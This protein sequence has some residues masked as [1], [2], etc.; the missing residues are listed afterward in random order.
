[1]VSGAGDGIGRQ[2]ALQLI[3]RGARVAAVGRTES[4]L[5]GTAAQSLAPERMSAHALD[6]SD[7]AAVFE[8]V[9]KVLAAHG[10]VDGV[11]NVAGV[12]QPFVTIDAL[13]LAEVERVMNVNFF[14]ALHMTQAFLPIL[15]SRPQAALVNVSSMGALVPV[16]GQG[17]Y[18]ASKSALKFLT[19]ALYAELRHTSVTVTLVLPGAIDT[20]IAA[21]SGADVQALIDAV[22]K[23]PTMK[24]T[25]TAARAILRAIERERFRVVVGRDARMVD[26]LS[27]MAPT[28]ATRIVAWRL[29][30]LVR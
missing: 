28:L 16:P 12:I 18:G 8:L 26:S 5:V 17:A 20:N 9:G 7:R 1:M 6:V 13:D 14:G 15:K 23:V 2:V 24:K 11:L 22:G 3:E 29:R 19:E 10:Q 27:R 25:D 4:R 30:A 21:N